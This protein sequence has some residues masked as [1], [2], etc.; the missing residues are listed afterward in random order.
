MVNTEKKE[1][2][3]TSF[4]SQLTVILLKSQLIKHLVQCRLCIRLTG[5]TRNV[6]G[7]H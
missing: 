2:S 7:K 3:Q 1:L 6:T 4:E 5:A